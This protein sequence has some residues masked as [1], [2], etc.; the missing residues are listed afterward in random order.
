MHTTTTTSQQQLAH[1]KN[2]IIQNQLYMNDEDIFSFLKPQDTTTTTATTLSTVS[3]SSMEE[4]ND[5]NETKSDFDKNC[6]KLSEENNNLSNDTDEKVE[7]ADDDNNYDQT[8]A[9]EIDEKKKSI[10]LGSEFDSSS[11]S[12]DSQEFP[13]IDLLSIEEVD[14]D[15]CN[16]LNNTV[17]K[18]H[19]R[20]SM[21]VWF[22]NKMKKM[23]ARP[24]MPG[25]ANANET[26]LKQ[27]ISTS[28]W[29]EVSTYLLYKQKEK[30]NIFYFEF[31]CNDNCTSS[32][33]LLHYACRNTDIPYS[34]IKRILTI[35]PDDVYEMDCS[36][37]NA[38]HIA[39]E[40]GV[41]SLDVIAILI[42]KN[43][44]AAQQPCSIGNTPLHWA[45]L[46]YKQK[47]QFVH[48]NN[49]NN[50]NNISSTATTII[51]YYIKLIKLLSTVAPNTIKAKNCVGVTPFEMIIYDR[52]SYTNTL[53]DILWKSDTSSTR[54]S[55]V[56]QYGSLQVERIND[57]S[58]NSMY[59][60]KRVATPNPYAS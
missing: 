10:L 28:K 24:N 27:L 6:Y 39:V 34:I 42:K 26:D 17:L 44:R 57:L 7:I 19:G 48:E 49:N 8:S 53:L 23:T 22:R 1:N 37:R 36:N 2:V 52:D 12:N 55:S 16:Q 20:A 18:D 46:G 60:Y 3:T 13:C 50:D 59:K 41:S 54:K 43:P 9:S 30:N 29:K 31:K 35:C 11:S 38:L 45:I 51:T 58:S 5:K 33:G 15:I 47:Q 25:T 40:C 32:H 21:T 14:D 56:K 4:Q